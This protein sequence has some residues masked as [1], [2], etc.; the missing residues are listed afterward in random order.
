MQSKSQ[1]RQRRLAWVALCSLVVVVCF[2]RTADGA[3]IGDADSSRA[4]RNE[5]Y[6]AVPFD[7]LTPAAKSKLNKILQRPSLYRRLPAQ[8]IVCDSDMHLFL[9]R[10]PEV[11]VNMWTMMGITKLDVSRTAPYEV[12]AVDGKGTVCDV[13][14]V[15]GTPKLHVTYAKGVYEGSVFRHKIKANCVCVIRTE[16]KRNAKQEVVVTSVLDFF[17]QF[18]G[19]ATE[20]LAKTIHPLINKAADHNFAE[21]MKFMERI[22]VAAEKNGPGV[23]RLS[24]KM[25]NIDVDTRK[26]FS[27]VANVV[28]QRAVMRE[29]AAQLP[30]S[31]GIPAVR[32]ARTQNE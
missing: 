3:S 19:F 4:A 2:T 30:E 10:H 1:R 15:Y 27:K 9:L 8:R 28:Y 23:E 6:N 20:L 12:R 22:N 26:Q 11:I 24:E 14:L 7:K 32:S 17:V 29:A 21:A 13:E 25:Q 16:Y 5:A 18:D 31:S